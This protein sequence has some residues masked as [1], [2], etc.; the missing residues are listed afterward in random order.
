MSDEA[1]DWLWIG[2]GEYT[3]A[4]GSDGPLYEVQVFKADPAAD[5]Y[6]DHWLTVDGYIDLSEPSAMD[7]EFAGAV[8]LDADQGSQ[9]HVGIVLV[10]VDATTLEWTTQV[11]DLADGEEETD[12]DWTADN[13]V[14]K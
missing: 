13:P 6:R 7:L 11:V 4:L 14:G 9:D 2:V 8:P 3:L 10:Y 1:H 5:V 12:V